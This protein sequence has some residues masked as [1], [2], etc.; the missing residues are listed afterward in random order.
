MRD[1]ILR[2]LTGK[3]SKN[4]LWLISGRMFQTVLSFLISIFTA[5]Y[6]GAGNFGLI[7]YASAYI[8][9]FS[10]V[11][12]LGLNFVIVKDFIDNPCDEGEAIGT[13]IVLKFIS[14]VLSSLGIICIVSIV[15]RNDGM[16]IAVVALSC[17]ALIF[18]SVDIINYWFLSKYRSKVT[19]V[20]TLIAYICTSLYKIILLISEKDVRWFAFASSIDYIVLSI[21][22]FATYKKYKGPKLLF[23]LEKAKNLLS[24]SHHYI[25]SGTLVA[26]YGQI[27]RVML[28]HMINVTDVGYYSLASTLSTIWTFVLTA[29]ID[30]MYPTIVSVYKE[31]EKGFARKNQQLYCLVIYISLAVTVLFVTTGEFLITQLYGNDFIGA[32]SPLKLLCL[33]TMFS[34]LGVAG[35]A[36]VVCTNNQKFLKYMYFLS[37]LFNIA[38]NYFMIPIWGASGAAL[39]SVITQILTNI[40]IPCF[41]PQLRPNILLIFKGLNPTCLFR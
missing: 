36:W 25:M 9:F 31:S 19:A 4:A 39:A 18:Q 29:I 10:S 30:S 35:N 14:S 13:S 12:N 27:D 17:F 38:L 3:E 6:L 5:R 23:S 41:I 28:K 37:A 40:I 15:D 22:L 33:N 32:V 26:V 7:N 2:T 16:T 11:C 24:V 20:A 1:K 34:Y 8:A 21:I